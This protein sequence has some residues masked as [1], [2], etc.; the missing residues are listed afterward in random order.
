MKKIIV[1]FLTIIVCSGFSYQKQIS[2]SDLNNNLKLLYKQKEYFRFKNLL[3]STKD[4]IESW[5]YLYFKALVDN[6]FNRHEE[7]NKIIETILNNYS[8]QINDTITS[9]LLEVQLANSIHLFEYKEAAKISKLLQKDY[10]PFLDTN[11][12]ADYINEIKIWSALT[13][14]PQQTTSKTKDSKIQMKKDWLGLLNIPVNVS[15]KTYEFIFDT[16]ANISTV[17]KSFAKKL[18]LTMLDTEFD[19]ET[20]T[21]I[22]I[23]SGLAVANELSI[24]DI[25]YHN[26]IFLVVP[27][28]TLS[29]PQINYSIDGIVGFPII[30]AME[31]IHITKDE[32]LIVP[33]KPEIKSL[34]NLA[35]DGLTPVVLGIHKNDSLSFAFDTGAM[36]THLHLSYYNKYKNEIDS[37]YEMR[38]ITIGGSGGSI[39]VKGF[40]LDDIVLSIGNAKANLD[41]V[42]LIAEEIKEKD[43]YF[44]GNLGQDVINQFDEMIINFESMYI[45]FLNK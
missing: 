45:E 9:K 4:K 32:E 23:K 6:A 42:R 8:E 44:Y 5:Q 33:L 25:I 34:E 20:A 14:I 17:T 16:G 35:F 41:N 2:D 19:I 15:G 26:V 40:I 1:L 27:D 38:T 30:E 10:N 29:F 22:K 21:D 36:M 7:S 18:G 12:L 39:D 11:D 43:N 31:E 37:K 24:G 28:E 3:N 13:D